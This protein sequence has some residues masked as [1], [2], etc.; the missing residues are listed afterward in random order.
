MSPSNLPTNHIS[1]LPPGFVPT[2]EEQS[3]LDLYRTV[4]Q[5]E[6]EAARLREAA[7]K[8]KL[9]AA[10]A[11]Y[12]RGLRATEEAP[13]QQ[14]AAGDRDEIQQELGKGKKEAGAAAEVS[15]A[16]VLVVDDEAKKR[17]IEEQDEA[18]EAFRLKHL[19]TVH[20]KEA[21]D[22]EE[23]ILP[24]LKRKMSKGGDKRA[25]SLIANIPGQATP[26]SEFDKRLNTDAANRA[27]A[28]VFP[29]NTSD[30]PSATSW[31]PPDKATN[32]FDGA[33]ELQL[34]DFEP[35]RLQEGSSNNTI[36]IKFAAP[37]ESKRFSLNLNIVG[38]PGHRCHGDVM[39][40]FNPRQ[41]RKGGQLVL[42][43]KRQ[44]IWGSALEIPLSMLPQTIFGSQ[45]C[46][47]FVQINVDGF[48]VFLDGT[49]CAR[50]EH[51]TQLPTE[52]CTL[53][54]Q[55]PSTD[56]YGCPEVW[57]VYRVWWGHKCSMSSDN[58][59]DVPGVNR[60]NALHSKK[61]FVSCLSKLHS[62]RELDLRQAEL[63]RAFH[64]YGGPH[65]V[66]VNARLN[67][68]F[69]FV[70]VETAEKADRALRE[71]ASSYRLNRAHQTKHE[72]LQEERA[73][74]KAVNEGKLNGSTGWD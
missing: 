18:A 14:S 59:S 44:G 6:R 26:P 17:K 30:R 32:P 68:S 66:A 52:K 46:T 25:A 35:L 20:V 31:T 9:Q 8:A 45:S 11:R 57:T 1:D 55:F 24:T 19:R 29:V 67:S 72:A 5:Y 13:A 39:F 65:G 69:A 2:P 15:G 63:E 56:D 28:I 41:H 47:L 36:A 73:A 3:L 50:F 12:Q 4:E 51:R 33:L 71:M 49:H 7:A 10:D 34:P 62:Q 27:G 16:V 58:I 74:A 42:N 48:D 21:N 43:D 53:T 61:L 60:H 70:E 64:R 54:L 40:H 22:S 38:R 37:S 23:L